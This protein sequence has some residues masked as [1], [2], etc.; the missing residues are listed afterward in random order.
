M[1]AVEQGTTESVD[2]V[3][4]E[5]EMETVKST[6]VERTGMIGVATMGPIAAKPATEKPATAKPAT[7]KPL[8]PTTTKPVEAKTEL[9]T[10]ARTI[11]P[12]PVL[13]ESRIYVNE[14]MERFPIPSFTS[15]VSW[16]D[17]SAKY[18]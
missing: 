1:E 4:K 8:T 5:L 9:P 13:N 11:N 14:V 3:S 12:S 17:L 2:E 6:E 7:A 10:T 18:K 15:S 16:D